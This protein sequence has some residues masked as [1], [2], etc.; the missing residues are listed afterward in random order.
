MK[1]PPLILLVDDLPENRILLDAFL[2]PEGFRLTQAASGEEALEK[3]RRQAPDLV[4]LDVLMPGL[5][6]FATCRRLREQPQ[7][8]FTPIIMIT[9]LNEIEDRIHGLEA[10][11]DDF[12]SKPFNDDLLLAKIRSLL[13]LKQQRDE[14]D[15]LRADFTN[16]IIHDLRAPVHSVLGLAELLREELPAGSNPTRLLSLL[17]QGARK[18][19]QLISQFL[20]LGKLE[21]GRLK[22][23]LEEVD[24]V[25]MAAG[26]IDQFEPVGRR[27]NLRFELQSAA[28]ELS[29]RADPGR[30]DQVLSNLLQNAVKFSPRDGRIRISLERSG[31]GVVCHV[32][33]DGPGF[34]GQEANTLFEKF[35][36]RDVQAGG[37]GLGLYVCR[38]IV[39]AHGGAIRAENRPGG[40]ARFTFQLP[41]G[42]ATSESE[43]DT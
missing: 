11:A 34:P 26:L 20:D 41:G 18:I 30:M 40:G 8:R 32:D 31:S 19:D 6:G 3:A 22:L 14:L 37:V 12:V 4:L 15:E 17:E 7:T 2:A 16:M 35:F 13:R 43:V 21:A 33:D 27:K 36:Q 1:K 25:R 24:L 10:G 42:S 5:D 38:A 39:E 29:V 28:P 9:A 23:R